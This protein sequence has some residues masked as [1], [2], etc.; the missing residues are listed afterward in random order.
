MWTDLLWSCGS[1][2]KHA[3][4]LSVSELRCLCGQAPGCD[5]EQ[6]GQRHAHE[7]GMLE[8]LVRCTGYSLLSAL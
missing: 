3:T 6:A 4:A 7:L 2:W 8:F 1:D 5:A